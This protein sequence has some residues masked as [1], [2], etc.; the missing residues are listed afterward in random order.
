[1]YLPYLNIWNIFVYFLKQIWKT[2]ITHLWYKCISDI[3]PHNK[4]MIE[5]M[6]TLEIILKIIKRMNEQLEYRASFHN[7]ID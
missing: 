2:N 3:I 6:I 1:M 5:E 7:P 4:E